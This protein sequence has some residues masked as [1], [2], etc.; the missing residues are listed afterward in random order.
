MGF[1]MNKIKDNILYLVLS[2]EYA[3]QRPIY[4]IAELA[5]DAGID[6]LQMRE[7]DLPEDGLIS[8]GRR[9]QSLCRKKAI[10]FIV[11]DNPYIAQKINADGLHLGQED[12]KR[13]PLARA[14]ALL[15]KE[16]IIGL[17][18]HSVYEFSLANE[19]DFDYIAYGPIFPT[20]T[21]DYNI[22]AK[23]IEAILRISKKPVVFIGG[24]DISNIDIL[25]L[26]GAKNIAVIRAI[27][28]AQDIAGAARL[29]KDRLKI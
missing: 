17:S 18:T 3:R 19:Q 26:Q 16:K 22:G 9:L 27:T 29:L 13:Y 12:I 23:D 10:P 20:K 7:K 15:G 5:I 28:E 21:K 8:L 14:R 1:F 4:D 2:S 25:I 6:M 24:I 11:N